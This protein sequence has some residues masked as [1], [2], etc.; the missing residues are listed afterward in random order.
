V[1]A[2][3]DRPQAPA[4]PVPA[5]Q[6][7][8]LERAGAE[9]LA[10][11]VVSSVEEGKRGFALF[12][13]ASGDRAAVAREV[14]AV[15]K[16]VGPEWVVAGSAAP[17]ESFA[18]VAAAVLARP[19]V[20]A[21]RI[22]VAGTGDGGRE[23]LRLALRN[24]EL[25]ASV[26]AVAPAML[27]EPELEAI[28]GVTAP[29]ALVHGREDPREPV[30]AILERSISAGGEGLAVDFASTVARA[31]VLDCDGRLQER[32][33]RFRAA[34]EARAAAETAVRGVLDEFHLAAS[35]ADGQRYFACLAPDA[36][37]VGTDA[38][39][40]WDVAAFRRFC[41]P[42][43]REGR[44]WTY[45]ATERHVALAGDRRTAW[46]DER[47]A[48]EK[49]GEVRGS[50]VLRLDGGRWR[51]AQYVMSFPIP[52]EVSGDVVRRIRELGK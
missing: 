23:A 35:K 8:T 16:A 24:P 2:P 50:G 12:V 4:A 52:N 40:R 26:V 9:P 49:Y 11:A 18:A 34:E 25:V 43:F 45:V 33:R 37:F 3:Q 31:T 10:Y 27:E 44:G 17:S 42:Y 38:T 48:N 15:A 1:A 41:E 30:L 13:A 21:A 19:D 6:E 22:H 5:V 36:I 20:G 51:I 28:S 47:L 32:L 7:R 39:E 46:F 14:G 29:V